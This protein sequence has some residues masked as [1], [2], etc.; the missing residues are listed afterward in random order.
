MLLDFSYLS[1][2]TQPGLCVSPKKEGGGKNGHPIFK[3]YQ[4]QKW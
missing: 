3:W 4:S 1:K 2:R